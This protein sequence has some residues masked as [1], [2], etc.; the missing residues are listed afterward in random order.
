M[1]KQHSRI[2]LVIAD[3]SQTGGPRQVFYLAAGLKKLGC[4][5]DVICPD[6]WLA[7]QLQ[8]EDINCYQL[9][10][11]QL[12]ITLIKTLK[13]LYARL[14][15][16]IIHC[17]GV[18]AGI[19]GVAA[20]DESEAQLVY[21]EHLWTSDFHLANPLRE[22]V[23]L[24]L[25]KVALRKADRVIAV[26]QTVKQFLLNRQLTED[27]KVVVIY[28]AITPLQ[29]SPIVSEP[30]IGTLAS[31]NRMKAIDVLIRALPAIVK[32]YP[33][34]RCLIGG[35]GPLA[36]SLKQLAKEQMV[37]EHIEWLGN[38]AN[39]VDFFTTLQV[40]VHPSWNES[41]GL[42]PLEAMSA[43]LP[44]VAASA[45]SL[46]EV[47]G[48]GNALFFKK[49]DHKD[50]ATKVIKLLSHKQLQQ[51]LRLNSRNRAKQFTIDR[52]VNEHAKVY[53]NLIGSS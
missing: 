23:Q 36:R 1:P 9:P 43:G 26:S 22:W 42:A 21:T 52:L 46:P 17:H 33:T 29:S 3:S 12:R 45:G 48:K 30:I 51:S 35:V 41:F 5:V 53:T 31:L 18:R 13:Q 14:Q 4:H 24:C 10:N 2:F 49:N 47:L 11:N 44:V 37:S 28:G 19:L 16:E 50:L 25:L 39:P 40:Y 32:Q 15:P 34:L 7:T 27:K 20:A 6:G 38:I 8:A